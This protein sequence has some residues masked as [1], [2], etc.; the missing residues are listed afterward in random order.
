MPVTHH[1]PAVGGA[2]QPDLGVISP[3]APELIPA[4]VA[5]ARR[6]WQAA[7]GDIL[8]DGQIDYMLEGRTDPAVLAGYIDASDKWYDVVVAAE[9]DPADPVVLG[10]SSCRMT[11]TATLR[12]EQIYVLPEL[13][14]QG[15]AD[16]LLTRVLERAHRAGAT[17]VDL[18][19][20]R[21]NARALSFYRKRKFTMVEEIVTDIGGG[22]VMDDFVLARAL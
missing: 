19:V 1:S 16:S 4:A 14:G 2:S 20:N 8:P 6:V 12:L 11:T 21:G 10:Y 5:C 9:T 18:T 3:L 22:F 17:T 7:Y 13:W 15:L